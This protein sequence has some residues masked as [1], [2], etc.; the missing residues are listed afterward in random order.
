VAAPSTAYTCTAHCIP[1]RYGVL[2][3]EIGLERLFDELR[4]RVLAPLAEALYP[5]ARQHALDHHHAFSVRYAQA[6]DRRLDMHHDD[7]E[8]TLNVCLGR[9]FE[10]AGL[11]FCGLYGSKEYRRHSVTYAHQPGH[12]VLH[13]GRQRHGADSITHGERVSL[14]LW[15]RSSSYRANEADEE[16]AAHLREPPDEVCLSYT[17]DIDF[18]RFRPLSPGVE[19]KRERLARLRAQGG[20]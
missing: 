8:V 15:A 6:G 16:G 3:D 9:H 5:A 7:S 2:V 12:A 11:T 10:G 20:G 13:L 4:Q 14:V 1:H 17:H 19:G 18:E